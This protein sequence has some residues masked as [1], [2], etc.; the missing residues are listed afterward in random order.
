MEWWDRIIRWFVLSVKYSGLYQLYHKKHETL[1]NNPLIHI[2]ISMINNRLVFKI[3][4]LY[5]LELE[6]P[7]NIKLFGSS[8]KLID[9]TKNAEHPPSLDVHVFLIKKSFF[10]WA[11]IL[12]N[13]VITILVKL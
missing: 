11:L 8:K 3:K 10:A 2:N 7:E 12:R 9:K 5:K 13:W 1:H 6:T 4:D